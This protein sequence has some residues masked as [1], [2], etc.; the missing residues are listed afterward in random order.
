M[1]ELGDYT[2]IP[3]GNPRFK[4]QRNHS[5]NY[6]NGHLKASRQGGRYRNPNFRG[7]DRRYRGSFRGQSNPRNNFQGQYNSENFFDSTF[8]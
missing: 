8:G 4:S 3:I 7:R 6:Y 2:K 1:K 5:G